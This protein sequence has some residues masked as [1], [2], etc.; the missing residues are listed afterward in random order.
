MKSKTLG[1]LLVIAGVIAFTLSGHSQKNAALVKDRT[2][3]ARELPIVDFSEAESRDAN[4]SAKQKAKASRYDRQSSQRIEAGYLISGRVWSTNWWRDLSALPF[5]QSDVVLIGGI[6]DAKAHLSNDKTGIYSEF[7]A[8]VQEVLKNSTSDPIHPGEV[9]SL[10]RF[11]GGVRFPSGAIQRYETVGQ[12]MP[13]A[14][15]TY[16]F[17]LK[18]MESTDFSIITG[19]QLDADAVSPLDGAIVEQGN[20]AY[21]FDIYRGVDRAT[22]LRIAKSQAALEPAEL[23]ASR[24]VL[25]CVC[26]FLFS[27]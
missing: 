10:E 8:Q 23:H 11:G 12:G 15:G 25:V 3:K 20:G 14:G 2:T 21:P 5:K 19:Y 9:I 4:A 18:Q 7:G 22:F 26:L 24:W 1:L 27:A 16:L 13:T 6:L 17:F